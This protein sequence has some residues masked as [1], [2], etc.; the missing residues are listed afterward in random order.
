MQ[1]PSTQRSMEDKLKRA[2]LLFFT[3]LLASCGGTIDRLNHIENFQPQTVVLTVD[4][5]D[6]LATQR[7]ATFKAVLGP[8]R[9]ASNSYSYLWDFRAA[10]GFTPS[11]RDEAGPSVKLPSQAGNFNVKLTLTNLSHP[12]SVATYHQAFN[13]I[14]DPGSAGLPVP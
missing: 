3:S 1:E 8:V 12:D 2:L 6:V 10:S 4:Y 9:D 13:V 11:S 7:T 5:Q 14:A